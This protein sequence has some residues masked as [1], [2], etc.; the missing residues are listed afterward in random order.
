MK[1]AVATSNGQVSEHFGHAPGFTT[2]IVTEEGI[3]D[4]TYIDNPG[5]NCQAIP[6]ML[7][8]LGIN[9]A[10]VG[11]IGGG[12]V[13]NLQANGIEVI[14]SASGPVEAVLEAFKTGTIEKGAVGCDHH[15]HDDHDCGK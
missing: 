8:G 2:A 5:G 13:S 3:T 4:V 12:A 1:V 11:G 14:G 10:I 7:A 9:V 6:M 15:D